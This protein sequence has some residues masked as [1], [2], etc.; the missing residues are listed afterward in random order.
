MNIAT[1]SKDIE[2]L[3]CRHIND[4]YKYLCKLSSTLW[5]LLVYGEDDETLVW[6]NVYFSE[7]EALYSFNHWNMKGEET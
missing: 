1:T 4:Y 7:R 3:K 2:V 6:D 5:A